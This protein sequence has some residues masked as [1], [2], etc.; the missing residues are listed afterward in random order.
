MTKK[1][2]WFALIGVLVA[3]NLY[4]QAPVPTVPPT[5]V[6][7]HIWRATDDPTS[8]TPFRTLVVPIPSAAVNCNLLP[9]IPATG[10]VMTPRIL[11]FDDWD[12]THVGKACQVDVATF[13]QSLPVGTGYRAT[14]RYFS[15]TAPTPRSSV[16]TVPFDVGLLLLAAP[17]RLVMRP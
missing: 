1:W 13:I 3:S 8:P 10:T 16:N 9:M 2:L 12:V 7:I 6:E 5:A 14:A 11:E 17:T 4:A 15:A